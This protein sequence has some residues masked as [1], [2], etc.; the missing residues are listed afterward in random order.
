MSASS[1]KNPTRNINRNAACV[2]Q[3]PMRRDHIERLLTPDDLAAM[4]AIPR[5]QVIRQAK[6]GNIPAIKI[7]KT[8][9]FRLSSIEAW[10]TDKEKRDS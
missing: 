3:N 1:P 9:R 8:W 4:L 10:L 2:G 6:R 5:L 7:G